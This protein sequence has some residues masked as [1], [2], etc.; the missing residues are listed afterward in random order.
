MGYRARLVAQGAAIGLVAL[1]FFLLAWSLLHD[2]GGDLSKR[3]NRGDRPAAPDFT[4]D[5]TLQ[6]IS[7]GVAEKPEES[8]VVKSL[9]DAVAK[10]GLDAKGIVKRVF[11]ALG[12]DMAQET[13]KLA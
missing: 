6:I 2:E 5:S 4:L 10:A 7:G 1:L 12:K 11:E 9:R 13:G 8:G 3:A